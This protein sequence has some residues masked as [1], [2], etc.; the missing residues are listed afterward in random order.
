LVAL[1]D[2]GVRL[3]AVALIFEQPPHAD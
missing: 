3:Q 1:D 2:L